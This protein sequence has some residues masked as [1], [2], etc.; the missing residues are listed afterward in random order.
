M[1]NPHQRVL[2]PQQVAKT[3]GISIATLWRW[4]KE[5]QDFPRP[6]PIGPRATGFDA[7]DVDAFIERCKGGEYKC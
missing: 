2:R 3:L 4:T 1:E 5:L 6:F 7:S